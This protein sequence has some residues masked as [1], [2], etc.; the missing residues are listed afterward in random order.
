MHLGAASVPG[1][2]GRASRKEPWGGGRGGGSPA[3]TARR[4]VLHQSRPLLS[5]GWAWAL[6]QEA[7]PCPLG[8]ASARRV[9]ATAGRS[10]QCADLR[11]KPER[12]LWSQLPS[13]GRP[14]RHRPQAA[15]LP[16][17]RLLRGNGKWLSHC[18]LTHRPTCLPLPPAFGPTG[19]GEPGPCSCQGASELPTPTQAN[20]PHSR[21]GSHEGTQSFCLPAPNSKL[22]SGA[23]YGSK[24]ARDQILH[25]LFNKKAPIK[26]VNTVQAAQRP[27][28]QA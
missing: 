4:D 11:G 18:W 12:S 17:R 23:R 7:A 3:P 25:F 13:P 26:Q 27:P 20:R 5:Q 10:G 19:V 15:A 24:E 1:N 9:P 6:R 2:S 16:W 8:S 28:E 21:R 22:V 14:G